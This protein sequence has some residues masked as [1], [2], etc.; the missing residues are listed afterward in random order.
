MFM[1]KLANNW[2]VWSWHN[3]ETKQSLLHQRATFQRLVENLRV[4][5]KVMKWTWWTLNC[6]KIIK[7][8]F[9][10]TVCWL[11]YSWPSYD[12]GPYGRGSEVHY[13]VTTSLTLL[14][15][16]FFMNLK[17][18]MISLCIKLLVIFLLSYLFLPLVTSHRRLGKSPT[19]I[20]LTFVLYVLHS[21]MFLMILGS[22][23]Y[24]HHDLHW[25][26]VASPVG[27]FTRLISRC[28]WY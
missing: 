28:R 7:V 4:G 2:L 1:L 19:E 14:A 10:L 5:V 23:T 27:T 17:F 24:I 11:L 25:T 6:T 13:N 22:H 9:M 8:L 16:L 12:A 18:K 20:L 3:G 26:D 21:S 15:K